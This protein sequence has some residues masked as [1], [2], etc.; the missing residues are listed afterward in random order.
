[1]NLAFA[2][3]SAATVGQRMGTIPVPEEGAEAPPT[4]SLLTTPL[5]HVTANNV[6]AH[7]AT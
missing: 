1:M 7:G 5:F 3:T 2:A 6:V 4:V